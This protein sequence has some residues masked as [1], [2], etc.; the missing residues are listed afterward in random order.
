ML[1][2]PA[3]E[4]SSHSRKSLVTAGILRQLTLAEAAVCHLVSHNPAPSYPFDHADRKHLMPTSTDPAKRAK[5]LANLKRGSSTH[6]AYSAEIIRSETQRILGELS[7]RYTGVPHDRLEVLAHHRA[8]ITVL[9]AYVNAKGII[10][11]QQKGEVFPAVKL[12]ATEEAAYRREMDR[13][14]ELSRAGDSAPAIT[15]A[16]IAARGRASIEA[17]AED[18]Q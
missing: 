16:A 14:E 2:C 3:T 5:Q 15:L 6:G 7:A 10:R 9:T 18:A 17:E 1:R 12:L 8:R 4:A 11:N 13:V